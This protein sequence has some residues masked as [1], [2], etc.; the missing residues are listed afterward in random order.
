MTRQNVVATAGKIVRG[1]PA[2]VVT[3]DRRQVASDATGGVGDELAAFAAG[4]DATG[5]CLSDGRLGGL[6]G[7]D[8]LDVQVGAL[9]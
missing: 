2:G 4:V 8:H 6:P 7:G 3:L 5:G 1:L 9:Y